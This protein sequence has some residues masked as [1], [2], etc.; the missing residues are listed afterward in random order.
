[1][2]NTAAAA[3]TDTEYTASFSAGEDSGGGY[4]NH[5]EAETATQALD[6]AVADV[7]SWAD[8]A[9]D[10]ARQNRSDV[11]VVVTLCGEG[12]RRDVALQPT[13]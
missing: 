8:W 10:E 6:L 11:K 9:D 12:M 7:G 5:Y 3:D 2:S 4:R 13:L 1:M